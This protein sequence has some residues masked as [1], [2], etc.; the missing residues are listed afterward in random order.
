MFLEWFDFRAFL[1]YFAVFFSLERLLP[2]NRAIAVLRAG[3][4]TDLL[5]FFFSG[6]VIRLGLF[7]VIVAAIGLGNIAIP[8]NLREWVAERDLWV[9]VLAATVIADLGFYLA[10]RMMHTVPWLWH[11]HAVHHSSEQ[12]DWLAAYRV[13][14]VDQVI[15]KGASYV[16][17]FALGFSDAAIAI[18]AII[19]HWQALAIHSNSDIRIGPLKWLLATPE[20]HHWHHSNHPEAYD[21]NYAGQLP[22]WDILFGTAHVSRG[23]MPDVYGVN[24]PVPTGYVD[25]LSYPF[26]QSL[27]KL[28]KS[29]AEE[30]EGPKATPC[31]AVEE[32]G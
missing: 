21:K 14:P 2:I 29:P 13:H 32:G 16:P 26:A 23:R 12:M 31:P 25:Q 30:V 15:V 24:E 27:R 22:V 9:Q 5:H 18:A 10:H 11:F 17:V 1:I 8:T 19:Y 6:I 20:F 4:T 28:V 3:W 7:V